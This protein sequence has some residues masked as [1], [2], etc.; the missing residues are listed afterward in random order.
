[1]GHPL[2]ERGALRSFLFMETDASKIGF[3]GPPAQRERAMA[4]KRKA[5][6]VRRV[7]NSGPPAVCGECMNVI[8]CESL[9]KALRV[10]EYW[11]GLGHDAYG[12]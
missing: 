9:L 4:K 3:G 11:S 10:A 6:G 1:M 2:G 12:K 8:D 7:R 5:A